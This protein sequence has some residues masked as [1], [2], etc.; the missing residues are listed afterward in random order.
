M[1]LAPDRMESSLNVH[2]AT[3]VQEF[4]D[5]GYLPER[6]FKFIWRCWAGLAV[7]TGIY[8]LMDEL[9]TGI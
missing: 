8:G 5:E 3:S 7:K 1:I 9:D 2:G 4:R 6:S